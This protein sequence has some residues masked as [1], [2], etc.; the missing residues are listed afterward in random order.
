[1]DYWAPILCKA[2]TKW[3]KITGC[4]VTAKWKNSPVKDKIKWK[5]DNKT[6]SLMASDYYI[7]AFHCY[8]S[9]FLL[10]ITHSLIPFCC[11]Y[12]FIWL[13]RHHQNIP[14][15]AWGEADNLMAAAQMGTLSIL[16]LGAKYYYIISI[17]TAYEI[18]SH[19]DTSK[20]FLR[21]KNSIYW[22]NHKIWLNTD[23][24]LIQFLI[25]IKLIAMV[26]K[27]LLICLTNTKRG[28]I[29]ILNF[30]F[31]K[32][33]ILSLNGI[34]SY[35]PGGIWTVQNDPYMLVHETCVLS[36]KALY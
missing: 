1:M 13:I 16:T 15:S 31:Q 36:Y 11:C 2:C 29:Y 30:Y 14:S 4:L 35:Q 7:R 27:V 12:S 18:H 34:A 21:E 20:V 28:Q 17:L 23:K 22:L 26:K 6:F 33:Y 8:Y 19:W 32:R 25:K 5:A 24:L 9:H 3:F 10:E